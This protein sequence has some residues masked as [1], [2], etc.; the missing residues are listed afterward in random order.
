[1][2]RIPAVVIALLA[3]VGLGTTREAAAAGVCSSTVQGNTKLS[4]VAPAQVSRAPADVKAVDISCEV[5]FSVLTGAGGN[6]SCWAFSNQVQLVQGAANTSLTSVINYNSAN[7]KP[8]GYTCYLRRFLQTV[9][10]NVDAASTSPGDVIVRTGTISTT[11]QR[12][13]P[14]SFQAAPK[15]ASP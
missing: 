6:T 13:L 10:E 14:R 11:S 1:M 15:R 7:Y 2:R 4:L 3:V 8:T 5:T 9:I 12:A